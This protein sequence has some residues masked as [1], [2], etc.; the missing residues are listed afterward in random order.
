MKRILLLCLLL[1]SAAV[2]QENRVVTIE[3]ENGDVY[4]VKQS[5][6]VFVSGQQHLWSYHPY[7]KSVTFK[8]QWPTTKVDVVTPPPNE[9]PAGSHEWCKAHEPFKYGF[10]FD[11]QLWVRVCD[12]NNDYKYG[13]GD[14]QFDAS[15]DGKACPE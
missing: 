6:N 14:T 9:N 10:T 11:D 12:T 3:Y 2:A 1:V 15:E 8:K 13:C 7:D 4:T 5:E